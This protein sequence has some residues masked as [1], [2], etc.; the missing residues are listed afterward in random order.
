L[1]HPAKY[2]DSIL[3]ALQAEVDDYREARRHPFPLVLDPFAGTG[4]IHELERCAT[5]G[6]EIEP[7]WAEMHDDTIEGD[8]T[9]LH[10]VSDAFINMVITSPAYGNRMADNFE[11]KDGR[12]EHTYRAALG[13]P[14]SDGSSGKLQWGGPYR[15]LHHKAWAEA[16]RV[17]R[18]GGRLV[19][20]TKDHPRNKVIEEVSAWHLGAV[21]LAH[22]EMSLLRAV[23]VETPG[24]RFGANKDMILDYEWVLVFEK[25]S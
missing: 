14:P 2:T 23:K 19:I 5:F 9:N 3:V 6:V 13:R 16:V 8:A 10:F 21:L 24:D 15:E 22:P 12:T 20:N 25:A 7:D 18:P 4:R 11:R 1:K 17:L